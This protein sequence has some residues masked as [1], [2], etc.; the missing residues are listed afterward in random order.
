MSD[1]LDVAP[2]NLLCVSRAERLHS[3]LFSGK[4]S[5]EVN[6][7]NAASQAVGHFAVG[8]DA[9]QKSIAVTLDGIG[10]PVDVRD[11]EPESDDAHEPSPA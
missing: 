5:R 1:D 8:E 10:D 3:R 11:V 9:S 4:P 6:R 2:E 7:R